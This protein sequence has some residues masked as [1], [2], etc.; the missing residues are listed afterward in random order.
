[1]TDPVYISESVQLL[2]KD[3]D[4]AVPQGELTRERLVELLTPI[5]GQLLNR[6]LERL[7]Q[8]CYRIDLGEERL[9]KLLH[10]A[11]P[12]TLAIELSEALVDRQLQ[13]VQIRRKYQ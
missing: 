3:F 11:N 8:I 2:Q 5:V 7:L 1:M 9:K 12:E 4:L 10:E 6:D 13:K